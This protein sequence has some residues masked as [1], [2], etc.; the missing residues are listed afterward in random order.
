M[1]LFHKLLVAPAAIGLLAPLSVSAGEVDIN[2]IGNYI[3][4]E[5]QE[6][7]FD[8]STFSNDLASLKNTPLNEI[9][10]PFYGAE[11]GSF[12]DTTVMSGSATFAVAGAD[13]EPSYSDPEALVFNYYLD[14]DL[15]TSFTGEDNLN[16][17]L[18]AGNTT[19]GTILSASYLDFGTGAGDTLSVVDVNYTR[20]FG[21]LTLA[22]GDS[23]KISNQFDGACAYSGFTTTLSDCGTG[24]SAGIGGDVTIAGS[25]DLGNGFTFGAGLS[26]TDGSTTKGIFTKESDDLYGLQLA[27]NADTYGAAVS[28]ANMDYD[29]SGGE[30][31]TTFWGINGYYSFDSV[32]DSISVG[33][34]TGDPDDGSKE[35]SMWFA[36][37]ATQP[38]GPGS[39]NFGI[40]TS[41]H[42]DADTEELL[43]YEANYAWDINDSIS[44]TAGVFTQERTSGANDITGVAFT[45][46][47]SF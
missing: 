17:G 40:G 4:T 13:G 12:S 16:I 37:I 18:E 5:E 9:K 32:I 10:S 8:S 39:I 41:Q 22:V 1:K 36:G 44:S 7:L 15:D 47:F 25:Y 28:Y 20:S 19:S 35:T 42:T 6:E 27:Y 43:I 30:A 29:A 45:T 3:I 46:T 24:A 14:L 2:S 33:Y 23:Y 38:I 34:E 26:S 31:D 21:D 11:A